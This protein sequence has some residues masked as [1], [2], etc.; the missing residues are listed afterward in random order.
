MSENV[1]YIRK[2]IGLNMNPELGGL[3][4]SLPSGPHWRQDL[5]LYYSTSWIAEFLYK[6]LA[7]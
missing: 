4:Q 5:S 2:Q 7:L 3:F 1:T 6:L